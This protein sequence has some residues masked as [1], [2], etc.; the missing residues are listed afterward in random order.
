MFYSDFPIDRFK[1]IK[2]KKVDCKAPGSFTLQTAIFHEVLAKQSHSARQMGSAD[3][4]SQ[5]SL[6]VL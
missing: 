5:P 3:K 1:K 2:K 4:G 6:Q